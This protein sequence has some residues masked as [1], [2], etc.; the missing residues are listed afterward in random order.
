MDIVNMS[1][2]GETILTLSNALCA[3]VDLFLDTNKMTVEEVVIA[4]FHFK[5]RT[6][7]SIS[8]PAELMAAL[9]TIA[10][11]ITKE[12][13]VTHEEQKTVVDDFYLDS[14]PVPSKHFH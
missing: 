5:H 12:A 6:T 3:A 13:K 2:N 8:L 1:L 14:L 4:I 7:S 11:S 10:E 9:D